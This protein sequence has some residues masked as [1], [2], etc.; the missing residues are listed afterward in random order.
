MKEHFNDRDTVVALRFNM[1]DVIDRRGHGT[2]ADCDEAL[3]HF[4][5]R[6]ACVAPDHAHHWNV[7]VRKNI[8]GHSGDRDH[9]DQHDQDRHHGEAVWPP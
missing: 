5:R 1:L 7:D 6:D 9:S 3:F 4:L 8:R 2:L